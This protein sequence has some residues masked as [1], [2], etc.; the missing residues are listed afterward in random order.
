M[1]MTERNSW[2]EGSIIYQLIPRSYSDGNGD[3]IADD[4]IMHADEIVESLKICSEP[5][6][7]GPISDFSVGFTNGLSNLCSEFAWSTTHS[8]V[9]T[10][11]SDSAS[12]C[13]KSGLKTAARM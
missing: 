8:M 11:G 4:E 10:S 3:G 7:F 2:W 13:Y 1:S 9:I 5:L 6:N 12:G